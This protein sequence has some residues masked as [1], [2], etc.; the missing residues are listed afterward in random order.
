MIKRTEIDGKIF[1]EQTTCYYY[2]NEGDLQ[3]HNPLY[4]TSNRKEFRDYVK[5][6]KSNH[7]RDENK[8][9]K[10]LVKNYPNIAKYV[11]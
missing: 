6:V 3:M 7:D 2:E 8:F 1:I 4:V 5:R 11:I 9:Y 10:F